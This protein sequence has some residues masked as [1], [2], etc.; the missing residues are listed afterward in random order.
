MERALEVLG[1][2]INQSMCCTAEQMDELHLPLLARVVAL[3][4]SCSLRSKQV[5]LVECLVESH[6]ALIEILLASYR[7][8]WSTQRVGSKPSSL[9][10]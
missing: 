2:D 6:I 5:A 7:A 10:S 9:E 4:K 1:A 8:G 3:P